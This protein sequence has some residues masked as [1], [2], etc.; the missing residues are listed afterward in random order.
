M[1]RFDSHSVLQFGDETILAT[2]CKVLFYT[3][4]NVLSLM[5]NTGFIYKPG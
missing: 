1:I 4:A 5:G 2:S 3:H